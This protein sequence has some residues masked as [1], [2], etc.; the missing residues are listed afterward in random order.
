MDIPQ[1]SDVE[2]AAKRIA[3]K[4]VRTPLLN[5]PVLDERTK[6]RVFI[7]PENLQ[8]TGSFKFR[9]AYNAISTMSQE[10]RDNGVYA[11]SSGNHA[12]GVAC[13]AK[14][15]GCSATILMPSDAPKIKI[16]RT[17]SHGATVVEFDREKDD[18]D[19]IARKFG[20]ESGMTFVH[21]YDNPKVVAGQG[22]VGREIAQDLEKLEVEPDRA[23]VCTGGGGLTSGVA[24]AL[25]HHF[26]KTRIH[27]SEPE[28]FDDY[29]RSL[30]AGELKRNA[31][32]AGSVCDSIIT[33]MPGK[34]GFEINRK[35]L[36]SGLV[37]SDQEALD[38]VRFAFE[39]LKLV[40]EPGGAV[41]LASLLK[42]CSQWEGETAV[43]TISGGNIDPDILQRALTTN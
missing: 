38:A 2:A 36:H 3:G 4:A 12:Q 8:R 33:T 16:A 43:I 25:S 10:A 30:E 22:T 9:G 11:I 15:F 20:E 34:I 31:K 32:T 6:M 35:L 14:L 41:A 18:R 37:V 19:V 28:G 21:P 17:R 29:R 23:I 26:P 24:L 1:Y 42:F 13:A 39:E 40:A 7:K 5:H 27:C